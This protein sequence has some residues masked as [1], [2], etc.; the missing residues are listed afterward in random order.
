M[1]I[2]MCRS[3]SPAI[4]SI[5][6]EVQQYGPRLID[7]GLALLR[8]ETV[9]PYNYV[10]HRAITQDRAGRALEGDAPVAKPEAAASGKPPRTIR[11]PSSVSSP[12]T[13]ARPSAQ[14]RDRLSR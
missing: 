4:A 14:S 1:L 5:S 13:P 6:H 10:E 11:K 8:G 3:S 2:E 7:L 12:R 9:A